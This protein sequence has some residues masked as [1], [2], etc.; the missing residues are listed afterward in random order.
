[1][2]L[3]VVP[4]NAA[5]VFKPVLF[6]SEYIH[7]LTTVL[8]YRCFCLPQDKGATKIFTMKMTR[9]DRHKTRKDDDKTRQSQAAQPKDDQ[10]ETRQENHCNVGGIEIDHSLIA[11]SSC[12]LIPF[13]FKRRKR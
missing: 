4:C 7:T 3:H 8:S 10:D 2:V 6:L 13:L 1:M 11:F 12:N 5:S 9:Q